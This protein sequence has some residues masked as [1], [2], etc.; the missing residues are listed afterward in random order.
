M[1]VLLH[2]HF[3]FTQDH[4]GSFSESWRTDWYAS[5]GSST[6]SST[7]QW[8]NKW[9]LCV[10]RLQCELGLA[11]R[12]GVGKLIGDDEWPIGIEQQP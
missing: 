6:S 2:W 12:W 1:Q 11:S 9:K 7:K 10:R 5:I 8:K 4:T 3:L